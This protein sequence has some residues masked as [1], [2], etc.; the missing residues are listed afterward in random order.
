M[1]SVDDRGVWP[2]L[3]PRL[4]GR[5]KERGDLLSWTLGVVAFFWVDLRVMV[6]SLETILCLFRIFQHN[7]F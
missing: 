7:T 6:M 1:D 5:E 2:S 3:S 4:S